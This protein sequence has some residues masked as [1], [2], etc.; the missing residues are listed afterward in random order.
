MR[1]FIALFLIF[2]FIPPAHSQEAN[3][4]VPEA[5]QVLV[6]RGA[7]IRYLGSEHGMD[8]WITIFQGQEQYY[9]VTPDGKAFIMGLL[10]NKDG[11][12]VTIEQVRSLQAKGGDVID[13]LAIDNEQESLASV[14]SESNEAFEYKTPAER[15]FEE[16]ENSN[17]L[18]F[19]SSNAPVVYSFMDP[20]CPHCH[21]FMKDLRN[22]YIENGLVQLRLIPV[23]FREETLAQSAFLLAAPDAEQ[24]WYQHLD[25]DNSA[26]P[27]KRDVNTR[28]VERNMMLMQN[29]N[30]D[31][32]PMTIYRDREGKVKII[33]GR[34]SNMNEILADLPS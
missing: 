7:Q 23:G 8:G 22:G 13:L 18:S 29:W 26:L 24:R 10:F 5:L 19:G 6:D 28:G 1:L 11:E 12:M 25:G 20:Q 32:T 3:P 27:A 33:R 30:F 9:Y 31:V 21:D 15:M 34:A 4:E 14:R 17:Y 2:S 16:V